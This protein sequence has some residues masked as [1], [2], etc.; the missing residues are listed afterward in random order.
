MGG[1]PPRRHTDRGPR[2]VPSVVRRRRSRGG[3]HPADRNARVIRHSLRVDVSA[4]APPGGDHL[5]ADVVAPA[6]PAA[7]RA[8]AVC[9]PGGGMNR[10]YWDLA[11]GTLPTY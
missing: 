1:A 5:A 3:R 10:R 2:S 8:L 9:W 6:G 11:E 7:P 4:V